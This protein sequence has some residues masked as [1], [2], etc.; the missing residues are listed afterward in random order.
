MHIELTSIL[1]QFAAAQARLHR[2][3]D[4]LTETRWAERA[5]SDQSR[6]GDFSLRSAPAI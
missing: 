5:T 2:L 6:V 3:A 4:D 1:D